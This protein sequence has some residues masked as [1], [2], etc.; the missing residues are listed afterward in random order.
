MK[1][2][3]IIFQYRTRSDLIEEEHRM[4]HRELEGIANIEFADAFDESIDWTDVD[5]LLGEYDGVILAGSGEY[6]FDGGRRDDD[7]K[8]LETQ[9][10][11]A[12][13]KPF[14]TYILEKDIPTLGICFGHQLLG[15]AAGV[16]VFHDKDQSKVG[17][18]PL[19]RREEANA[20]PLFKDLPGEFYAQYG[21]K[22]SLGAVP[23]GATLLAANSEQC[24]CSALR[25]GNCVYTVQFHPEFN[26]EDLTWRLQNTP[27]YLPE[28]VDVQEL[29]RPTPHAA[30]ILEEFARTI[31]TSS[32]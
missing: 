31:A 24:N 29:V 12:R 14:L 21:H 28:G 3:I 26:A 5:T 23:A 30:H 1:S 13:K 11:F 20:D 17:S 16:D 25:Y 9:D 27:G 6:D 4:F 2:R 15:H 7:E 18:H 19:Y 22:D 10:L 32:R 8:R